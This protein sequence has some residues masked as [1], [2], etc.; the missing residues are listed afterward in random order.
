[1]ITMDPRR[2]PARPGLVRLGPTQSAARGVVLDLHPTRRE[3]R[4]TSVWQG[5]TPSNYYYYYS[6]MLCEGSPP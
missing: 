5:Q 4:R 6:R 1:M 3:I 2:R